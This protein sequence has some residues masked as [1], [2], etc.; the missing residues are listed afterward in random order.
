MMRTR[1]RLLLAAPFVLSVL[2]LVVNDH[3]AKAT[4]P[5]TVTGKVSD[6][7]G[8]VM[9]A[10]LLTALS[11]RRSIG[12]LV[13]AVG[14]TAL[15]LVPAVA[16]A[17]EPILGGTTRTDPSDLIALAVLLPLWGWVSDR[18]PDRE[19]LDSAWLFPL[20][21]VAVSAAVFATTATSCGDEG[22]LGLAVSDGIAYA[23]TSDGVYESA[24]G[25]ATWARSTVAF[26]DGRLQRGWPDSLESCIG[27]DPC[28][29]IV[30]PRTGQTEL[31]VEER[32]S[33][34]KRP[35]LVVSNEQG[36]ALREVVRP[37]CGGGFG[38]ILAV[39]RDDGEHVVLT[40]SEAGVLHHGPGGTWEW[41]AVG[42]F[43]LR[44]GQVAEEPFGFDA[45]STVPDDPWAGWPASV[46]T[47][48]LVL[49]PLAVFL[50]I[51][52]IY[53]LAKRQNRNPALAIVI[54]V[55]VSV[56]L[57]M[58]GFA[59]WAVTDGFDNPSGR[60]LAAACIA[61]VAVATVVAL[62]AWHGRPRRPA[63]WTP[64]DASR[65]AG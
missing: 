5:G 53:G 57:A 35:L 38:E 11:G 34:H 18:R 59:V 10:I 20:Q 1:H 22:V 27:S 46:A 15:K 64:P 29:T 60:A 36:Q 12:F 39:D 37:T 33:G 51:I 4:W 48:F 54:C 45:R 28:F 49:A 6:F 63:N 9:M 47:V 2:V 14:F 65:R 3:V 55:V 32:R 21:I 24:D 41:V 26:G 23:A 43:G 31:I 19:R 30:R 44:S 42:E 8:V 58:F 13:T 62:L 61:G 50:S 7:A 52:P 25:G 40:M 16:A 17:A 56:V